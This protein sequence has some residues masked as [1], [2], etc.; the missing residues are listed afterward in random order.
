MD[1]SIQSYLDSK[2][3]NVTTKD[4]LKNFAT[5][6]DIKN[7]ATK[8]DLTHLATKDDLKNFTTKEDLNTA[9][10]DLGR[11]ISETI[12]EPMEK[13]FAEHKR[14]ID[15][16]KDVEMLKR[17]MQKIKDALAM[18]DDQPIKVSWE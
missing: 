16:S 13:H 2:F 10:A 11:L 18:N 5:K 6:D 3:E 9:V 14:D 4:D 17:D 15:V 7:M 12:A 1:E 8:D